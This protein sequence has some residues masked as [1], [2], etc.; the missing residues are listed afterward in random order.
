MTPSKSISCEYICNT[1]LRIIIFYTKNRPTLLLYR[2]SSQ[3]SFLS[4]QCALTW[5]SI[6]KDLL[7]LQ[8]RPLP[9]PLPWRGGPWEADQ[10]PPLPPMLLAFPLIGSPLFVCLCAWNIGPW[11]KLSWDSDYN[12]LYQ[13]YSQFFAEQ[14][15]LPVC[16]VPKIIWI[17]KLKPI[18]T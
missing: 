12:I 6:G 3:S 9:L 17:F 1:K 4:L 16:N 11:I 7:P 14:L 8:L 18:K 15:N 13:R 5:L 2:Y 10:P